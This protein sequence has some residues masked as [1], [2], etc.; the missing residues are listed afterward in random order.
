L[1]VD[2]RT[3]GEAELPLV[4]AA[5]KAPRDQMNTV[6]RVFR[7]WKI[8]QDFPVPCPKLPPVGLPIS[9]I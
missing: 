6:E 5:F 1:A 8:D 2:V 9:W 7:P 3:L 4:V